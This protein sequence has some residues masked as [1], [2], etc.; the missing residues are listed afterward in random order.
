[1][2][3]IL[4]NIKRDILNDMHV[5]LTKKSV[6]TNDFKSTF[7]FVSDDN[8]IIGDFIELD[9]KNLPELF[10]HLIRLDKTNAKK[11]FLIFDRYSISLNKLAKDFSKITHVD[12]YYMN[13]NKTYKLPDDNKKAK[14]EEL[15]AKRKRLLSIGAWDEESIKK[16]EEVRKN[17][18][19]KIQKF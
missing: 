5:S 12:F 15:E 10:N 8:K 4:D 11:K 13:E 6:S 14:A 9:E 7:K 2:R 16:I 1:M 3:T 19:W 17:F 18:K